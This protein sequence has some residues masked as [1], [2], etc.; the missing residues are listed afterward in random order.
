[1]AKSLNSQV[2]RRRLYAQAAIR[3][4]CTLLPFRQARLSPCRIGL[5]VRHCR[6]SINA[7]LRGRAGLELIIPPLDHHS[8]LA[9]IAD[10]NTSRGAIAGYVGRKDADIAH[11]IN[12][13]EDA[14]LIIREPDAFRDRRSW[15][16]NYADQDCLGG[17]PAKVGQG[18]INDA[19]GKSVHQVDV[20]VTGI[21]DSKKTPLLAI[22]EGKWGEVCRPAQQQPGPGRRLLV[23]E[24]A[25]SLLDDGGKRLYRNTVMRTVLPTRRDGQLRHSL[26]VAGGAS[27]RVPRSPTSGQ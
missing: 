19:A 10:G 11:P 23:P 18:A 14:R 7:P 26:M 8:V 17:L 25:E 9:A 16:L 20:V 21:G 2:R 13:L 15:T 12:V 6:K 3:T 24:R 4:S 1:M 22:S 27:C 5:H